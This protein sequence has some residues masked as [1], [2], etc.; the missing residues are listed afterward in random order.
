MC[1]DYNPFR[2][3]Q[4]G[5]DAGRRGFTLVELLVVIGII[6]VLIAILLPSLQKARE[7]SKSVAC[8]SNLRQL[9]VML[10]TYINE[11]KGW[12]F[13]V[14]PRSPITNKPTTLGT[15]VMPHLRWPAVLFRRDLPS[16]N[17][18][19]PYPDDPAAYLASEAGTHGNPGAVAA[20]LQRYPAEPFTPK[21]LVCP[22]EFEPA[23]AHSYVLNQHLADYG[24]K[25]GSKNFG[26]LTSSQVIVA[27]EKV[28]QERD[29]HMERVNGDNTEFDRVVEKYRHGVRLGSNY[30][31]HDGHVDTLSPPEALTGID[32]WAPKL[33]DPTTNPAP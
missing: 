11:N 15:N 30:L 28:T 3:R 18:P 33:P 12:L 17:Q 24:V 6:G 9:G 22:S 5:S 8:K 14:G 31:Y 1:N 27:G 16:L 32:P 2:R 25:F 7:Q 29:Y 13:P 23:D 21:V 10:Q 20:H 19:L 4:L 26:G